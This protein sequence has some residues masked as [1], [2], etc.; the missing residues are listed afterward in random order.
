MY[1][2]SEREREREKERDFVF[3]SST[4]FVSM[5][6]SWRQ[7][8]LRAILHENQPAVI[9]FQVAVRWMKRWCP[10]TGRKQCHGQVN[11]EQPFSMGISKTIA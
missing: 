10:L 6:H 1:R 11:G 8:F 4:P 7:P 9:D 5:C 2:H 3:C